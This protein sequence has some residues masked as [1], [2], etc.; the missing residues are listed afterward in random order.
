MLVHRHVHF[1]AHVFENTEQRCGFFGVGVFTLGT[2]VP[3]DEF[4]VCLGTEEAP[5]HHTAGVDEVLDKVVRL[6]HRVAF[7]GRLRQVVQ[8]FETAAL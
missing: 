4:E 7:E 3:L 2:E 8:A 1:F 6:G 5:R